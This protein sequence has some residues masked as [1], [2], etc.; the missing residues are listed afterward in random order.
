[1]Y[2]RRIFFGEDENFKDKLK[3]RVKSAFFVYSPDWQP[4]FC[5]EPS[6]IELSDFGFGMLGGNWLENVLPELRRSV[7]VIGADVSGTRGSLLRFRDVDLMTPTERELRAAVQ[8]APER[9]EL[10][11]E[12]GSLLAQQLHL[13]EAAE[14]FSEAV[15]LQPEFADA[16]FHLGVVHWR[17]SD[18]SSMAVR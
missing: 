14:E 18:F 15:R 3:E 12:L 10:H 13:D 2:P 7:S 1:M 4:E 9:A 11:D 5:E 8:L 16:R 17:K 6:R